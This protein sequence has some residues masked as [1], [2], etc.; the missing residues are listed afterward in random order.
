MKLVLI[1]NGAAL[2]RQGIYKLMDSTFSCDWVFGQNDDDI[3]QMDFTTLKGKVT[4][5]HIKQFF[6][7]KLYWQKNVANALFKDYSHYI[8]IGEER[9]LSIW[10]F[11]L[12]SKLFRR[13]K[14]YFWTH[15][16]YGKER[17][18]K[19]F[20]S[21][22]FFKMGYGSF[23]YSNYSRDLLIRRG[24]SPERLFTIHNSL[25]YDRQ[26]KLR[27]T[28][29]SSDL[30]QRHFDNN[31]P[32]LLFIGRL[33]KVKKLDLL[34]DAVKKL[35]EQGKLYNLVF[36][37]DGSEKETLIRYVEKNELNRHVWFY[38][39]C[40][41]E[42][43]NA[44]LIHNADLCVAPGN[45]GLTAMHTMVFGTPVI[46]HNNFPWQMPEFEA[47]HP[48]ETGDFF[49]MDNVDSLAKTIQKWFE[50]GKSREIIRKA[51][52]NEIDTQWNPQYQI[53]VLKKG[54]A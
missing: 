20:I 35:K 42:K 16:A 46:S 52:Y 12:L 6:G 9:N 51:C 44:V 19:L 17:G 22:L 37:G 24:F 34:I 39:A 8:V 28:E 50:N 4:L 3:K 47:I 7:G 43:N 53:E 41:D 27:N 31:N 15:G 23:V 30:Y 33:T 48:G 21:N 36:V 25:D 54:L 10:L 5:G 26:V 38:G 49:E 45:V 13:K 40:Y 1:N 14:V 11:L 18:L 2:Y 29:L 32:V